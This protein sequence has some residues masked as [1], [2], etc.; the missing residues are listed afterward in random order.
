MPL[1]ILSQLQYS[2]VLGWILLLTGAILS[3]LLS[4]TI[5]KEKKYKV[6]KFC[7]LCIGMLVLIFCITLVLLYILFHFFPQQESLAVLIK[8]ILI[9]QGKDFIIP[10]ATTLFAGYALSSVPSK[11]KLARILFCI[12]LAL[13]TTLNSM[14]FFL[15]SFRMLQRPHYDAPVE[16]VS[17]IINSRLSTYPLALSKDIMNMIGDGSDLLPPEE[18]EDTY[19]ENL[20]EG[21]NTPEYKEPDTFSGYIHAMISG[22]YDPDGTAEIYLRKAYALFQAGKHNDDLFYI[23][24]MWD[25]FSDYFYLFDA[26][27]EI[28]EEECLKNALEA[29]LRY[30]EEHIQSGDTVNLAPLYNNMNIVYNKLGDRENL[31]SCVVKALN[32][33]IGSSSV[34]SNYIFDICNWLDDESPELLMQDAATVIEYTRADTNVPE[35][36]SMYILYGACAAASNKNV[37]TAYELLCEADEYFQGG[38]ALLKILRC[39][40]ADLIN[41]NDLSTL[42]EI[43]AMEEEAQLTEVEEV[44]LIRYLFAANRYEE[45]WGYLSDVGVR[46]KDYFAEQTAIKAVW[47]FRNPNM[48]IADTESIE[49]LLQQIE[50]ELDA[51][52]PAE[53]ELLLLSQMLLN[54][55]LGQPEIGGIETYNFNELSNVQYVFCATDAF[56]NAEYEAAIRYCEAFF[57][58]EKNQTQAGSDNAFS[59]WRLEPQE[60]LALH[61][62]TQLI[63]A[64]SHFECAKKS[65]KGT[66]EWNLHMEI[67]EKECAVFKQSSKS[68]LYIGEKFETLQKLIDSEHGT[69]SEDFGNGAEAIFEPD[70]L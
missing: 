59:I 8:K 33:D 44:Y 37:E 53:E 65:S 32:Y 40:C 62:H 10:L 46:M 15:N 13:S 14:M 27:L 49:L 52:L 11:G 16:S 68:L 66:D 31:R 63:L 34:M 17:A 24:L 45:L 35:N 6:L 18:N 5:F 9:Q 12:F 50:A 54:N 60:Q 43:Y 36:L 58:T 4:E 55:T 26:E 22:N 51:C 23:G 56:N 67:A 29:Y 2:T 69:L 41:E 30:E 47:Y 3:A 64:H 57:E 19:S 38:S 61:Y 1:K 39:I 42:H 21:S 7:A 28:T 48:A 70:K 25:Y 20:N